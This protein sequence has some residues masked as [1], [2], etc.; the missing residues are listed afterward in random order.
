MPILTIADKVVAEAFLYPVQD[1]SVPK[2]N[3]HTVVQWSRM[4]YQK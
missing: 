3:S 1:K 2:E 4:I